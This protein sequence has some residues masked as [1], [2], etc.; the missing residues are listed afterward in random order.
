MARTVTAWEFLYGGLAFAAAG[1]LAM[2]GSITSLT[3]EVPRP[4]FALVAIEAAFGALLIGIGVFWLSRFDRL[5]QRET[6]PR[7]D[8][9]LTR[10]PHRPPDPRA[11]T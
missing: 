7:A 1:I 11:E 5:R 8:R 6:I 3:V 2:V 9:G 10:P 4:S